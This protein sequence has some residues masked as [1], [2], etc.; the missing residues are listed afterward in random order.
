MQIIIKIDEKE[1]LEVLELIKQFEG[2][3]VSIAKVAEAGDLNPNRTRFVF[4][5][6]IE[7]GRLERI[8]VKDYGPRYRRYAYKIK[9]AK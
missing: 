8:V 7:E 9:E 2:Q 1:K 4:A 6:L 3:Q 5:E